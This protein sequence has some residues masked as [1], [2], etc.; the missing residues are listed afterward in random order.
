MLAFLK[1]R[2]TSRAAPTPPPPTRISPEIL[3]QV[4][5]VELKTRGL[6]DALFAGE[7]RSVFKGQGME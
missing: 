7:Y 5:R 6:V 2:G 4:K 3:K 1:R